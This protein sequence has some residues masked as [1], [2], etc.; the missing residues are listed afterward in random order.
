MITAD[1]ERKTL[2]TREVVSQLRKV[3][4]PEIGL[5]IVDL[6]LIYNIRIEA[7]IVLVTFSLTNPM[8]PMSQVIADGIRAS[9]C[10]LSNVTHCRVELASDPPW[11][12][13]MISEEGR[14]YIGMA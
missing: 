9:V 4:D 7:D 6:G 1:H 10:N 8:C 12:P 13:S 5:N 11:N 14:R 2:T 3:T